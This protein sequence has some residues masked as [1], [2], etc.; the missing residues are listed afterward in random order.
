MIAVNNSPYEISI[1]KRTLYTNFEKGNIFLVY[2]G[3][4]EDE[5]GF[6]LIPDTEEGWLKNYLTAMVKK[7]IIETVLANSDNT[8]NEQFL[9]TLYAQQAQ[10]AYVKAMGEMKLK[11]VLQ[12]MKNY[13]SKLKREISVYNFGRYTYNNRYGSRTEFIIL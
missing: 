9:Y 12:G 8:T 11:R 2:N 5:D 7:N 3:Y 10:D 1:N 4:E 13:K 6:L